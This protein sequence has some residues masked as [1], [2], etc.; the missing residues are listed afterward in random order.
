M[1][2]ASYLY[3]LCQGL[4]LRALRLEFFLSMETIL[5]EELTTSFS[6][7]L[8]PSNQSSLYNKIIKTM[9]D[10]FDK[11]TTMDSADQMFAV[12]SS[13]TSILIDFFERPEYTGDGTF[14]VPSLSDISTFRTRVSTRLTARH[15]ELRGDF[16][17]RKRGTAPASPYLGRTRGMYEFIRQEL[18]IPMHGS[19]NFRMFANGLGVDE[20]S[21]GQKISKIYEVRCYCVFCI[22][23][24][25]TAFF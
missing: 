17:T 5:K 21:I 18:G 2:V 22:A 24:S 9:M 10:T 12:A 3:L 23:S 1:L 16:L 7:C 4:D 13:S 14:T 20:P 8:S 15:A 11:T 25:L 19:E 6:T